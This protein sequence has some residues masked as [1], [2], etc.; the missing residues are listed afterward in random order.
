MDVK[1]SS[2]VAEGERPSLRR[3]PRALISPVNLEL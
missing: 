1:L 2:S 3:K